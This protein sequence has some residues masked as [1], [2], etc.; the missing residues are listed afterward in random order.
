[1]IKKG[2]LFILFCCILQNTHAL[3][4][5]IT[6]KSLEVHLHGEYNRSSNFNGS[7]FIIGNIEINNI[8]LFKGGFSFGKI[9]N[10]T[11]LKSFASASVSPFSNIPV[12]FSL[13]WIYNGLMEFDIHSHTLMPLV[14]YNGSRAGI[15]LGLNLRF[16]SFFGE[17]PQFESILSYLLYLNFINTNTLKIGISAGNFDDFTAKNMLGFMI[18]FSAAVQINDNWI[19]INRIEAMQS[20]I[21][22]LSTN[23]YGFAW[24]VGVRY[25]W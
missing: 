2:V 6:N 12:I 11:D 18:S 10:V 9:I 20:G 22:G 1:M 3:D 4:L 24:K 13:S 7:A 19:I 14:S 21:D 23:F 15:S 5:T 17:A 25:T 8:Y 16:T